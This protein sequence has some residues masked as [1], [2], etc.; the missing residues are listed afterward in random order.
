MA[1][2]TLPN[3]FVGCS[4]DS[5]NRIKNLFR[6]TPQLSQCSWCTPESTPGAC[7]GGY[8]CQSLA[9]VHDLEDDQAFCLRHFYARGGVQ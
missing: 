9:T 8:P 5:L 7:D 2:T 1:S 6:F 3:S 4:L